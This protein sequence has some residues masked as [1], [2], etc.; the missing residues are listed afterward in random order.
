[1]EEFQIF[2]RRIEI[3]RGKH[4]E[5]FVQFFAAAIIGKHQTIDERPFSLRNHRVVG[6]HCDL[7]ELLLRIVENSRRS[8]AMINECFNSKFGLSHTRVNNLGEA[9]A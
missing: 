2:E 5:R 1:M 9:R 4:G 7:K 3:K 6:A 8:N